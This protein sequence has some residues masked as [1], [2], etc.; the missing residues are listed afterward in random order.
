MKLLTEWEPM[1][2]KIAIFHTLLGSLPQLWLAWQMMRNGD[3]LDRLAL[4]PAITLIVV[5]LP[6]LVWKR[7]SLKLAC[8]GL[9]KYETNRHQETW[10]D[11]E[12]KIFWLPIFQMQSGMF[13]IFKIS[14]I[15]LVRLFKRAQ[16]QDEIW[17]RDYTY[18]INEP[19]D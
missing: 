16:D 4:H 19:D 2:I 18:L 13:F 12:P 10:I 11:N 5:F 17:R 7:I 3:I 9:S 8:K 6:G 15:V 14:I 1:Q